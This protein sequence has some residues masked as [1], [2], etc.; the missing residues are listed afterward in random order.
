MTVSR[1]LDDYVARWVASRER[2]VI[3]CD[4]HIYVEAGF[5]PGWIYELVYAA[6][7]PIVLGLGHVA[8]RD[9]VS[10]LKHGDEGNPLKGGVEKA[11]A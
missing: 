7:D 4:T 6:R 11:Y 2:A 10:F 9:F 5:E 1:G 8:V 3:P